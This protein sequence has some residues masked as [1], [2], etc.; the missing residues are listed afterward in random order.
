MTAARHTFTWEPGA[1]FYYNLAL[2]DAS[3]ALI[4][5]T[6]WRAEFSIRKEPEDAAALYYASSALLL[7]FVGRFEAGTASERNV[8]ITIP[9]AVT[10]GV[11]GF[12]RGV[13]SLD[14]TDFP[15]GGIVTR[16]LEGHIVESPRVIR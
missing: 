7:L 9:G 11:A 14:M 4:D 10:A 13:Y 16:V 2:Y 5:T 1:A 8:R 15:G 3:H 12:G 6:G